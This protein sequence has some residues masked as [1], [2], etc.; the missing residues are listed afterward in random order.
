MWPPKGVKIA[1][2]KNTNLEWHCID[3]LFLGLFT[4]ISSSIHIYNIQSYHFPISGI[5]RIISPFIWE[6]ELDTDINQLKI[7]QGI[8]CAWPDRTFV[9]THDLE[10]WLWVYLF[11]LANSS[12]EIKILLSSDLCY[13]LSFISIV[14]P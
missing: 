11:L 6:E 1:R 4:K 5:S 14:M 7:G 12:T 10:V 13:C 8:T 9:N 3:I 2:L